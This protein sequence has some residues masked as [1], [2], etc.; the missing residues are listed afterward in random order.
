MIDPRA[1]IHPDAKIAANVS[2]G[3]W[4]IIGPDVEIGEGTVIGSHVVIPA[5]TRIG[6]NNKIYQFSSVGEDPQDKKYHGEITTLEMG[7]DN[8]IREC[9]TINRG[10]VQGGGVTRIGNGNLLMAYVHIAHDCIIA[11]NAIFANYVGLAGHVTVEDY[12][13]FGGYAAVHQFCIVGAH[14]F[15]GKSSMV[16]KDVLPYVLV[17]GAEPVACGIN[18]EGLKRRNFS[19]DTINQLRRAYKIIFRNDLTVVQAVAELEKMLT[20]CPEVQPLIAAMQKSTR[21]IVR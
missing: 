2:V 12:A 9:C 3:P 21:G 5:H 1:D 18:V 14:S 15:V 13:I 10:T 19:A 8:V 17:S 7:D 16:T 20:D 6:K 11:N 4:T